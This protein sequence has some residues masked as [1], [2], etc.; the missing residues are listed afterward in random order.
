MLQLFE[1]T[2]TQ[3]S[4]DVTT[5]DH[6]RTWVDRTFKIN[7]TWLGFV[8]DIKKLTF[9]LRKDLSPTRLIEKD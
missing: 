9:I 7:N 8:N 2:M 4:R 3:Q 1:F 5:V 6:R